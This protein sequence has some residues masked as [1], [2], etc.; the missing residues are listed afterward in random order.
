MPHQAERREVQRLQALHKYNI[1]DTPAEDFFDDI[2]VLAALIC[3]TPIS[4]IS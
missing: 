1:L 3:S 4:L 2:A